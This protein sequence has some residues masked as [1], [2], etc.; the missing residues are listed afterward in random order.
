MTISV[1]LVWLLVG[2]ALCAA[3]LLT[4]TFY[5]LIL[6][7]GCLSGSVAAW[8]GL[9]FGWQCTV[10]AVVAAIAGFALKRWRA[11]Q[12]DARSDALQH[13]DVGQIVTV[14]QWSDDRTATVRYRGAPWVCQLQDG[15]EL[16]VGAHRVVAV[17]GS[18][19]IVR[20]VKA[21]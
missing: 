13:L 6:G 1:T 11:T 7:L 12:A 18:R 2:L 21:E 19:L 20:P 8:A 10:G 5:L 17:E 16:A 3:E 14:A 15:A 9:D 4:G